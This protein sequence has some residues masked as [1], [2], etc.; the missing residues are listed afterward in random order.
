MATNMKKK[1]IFCG[2]AGGLYKE[3]K[4]KE[5]CVF[6]EL[7]FFNVVFQNNYFKI[8]ILQKTKL[9]YTCLK[10]LIVACLI[11]AS[12]TELLSFCVFDYYREVINYYY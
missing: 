1:N 10:C 9:K 4:F 11:V 2:T 6:I 7:L 5:L 12:L 8:Y 3:L